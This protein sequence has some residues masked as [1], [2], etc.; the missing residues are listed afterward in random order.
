MTTADVCTHAL[1]IR[2]AAEQFPDAWHE[3]ANQLAKAHADDGVLLQPLCV[4]V[5]ASYL[6]C[7]TKTPSGNTVFSAALSRDTCQNP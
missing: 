7:V 6:H 4:W 3:V 5:S 1:S 2:D